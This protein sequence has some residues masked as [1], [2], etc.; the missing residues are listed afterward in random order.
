MRNR[1]FEVGERWLRRTRA[2]LGVAVGLLFGWG[3][4]HALPDDFASTMVIPVQSIL[5]LVVVAA[6]AG[7]VAA[8]LPA[9]RAGRL[10]VLNAISH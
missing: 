2:V 4:V 5:T 7:V 10:N 8:V 1:G 9:R 3:V 6:L